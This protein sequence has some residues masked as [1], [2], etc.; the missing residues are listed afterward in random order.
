MLLD[1]NDYKPTFRG[2]EIP[3]IIQKLL[4]LQNEVEFE[5]F[6][7]GFELQALDNPYLRT[8]TENPE[9]FKAA[10]E[11]AEASASGDVYAF[12]LRNGNTDLNNAPILRFCGDQAWGDVVAENLVG[13]VQLLSIDSENYERDED[14][15]ESGNHQG[16][17]KLMREELHIEPITDR[18]LILKPAE[19]KYQKDF[20]AWFTTYITL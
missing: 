12:W 5:Y 4:K 17:L 2:L 14:Y 1:I 10:I 8:G 9:C 6:S 3:V 13:L 18:H 20:M 19:E 11:F 16:L 15:T 7:N